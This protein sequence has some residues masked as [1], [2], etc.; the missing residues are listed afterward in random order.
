MRIHIPAK[1]NDD[2]Q[3]V[4]LVSRVASGL[5][6][7]NVPEQVFVIQID[8]WFDQKWLNFSGIGRVG[9]DSP[10]ADTAL[11]EFRQDKITFPPFSPNRVVEEY[12]FLRGENG[13]YAPSEHTSFV[14][15]R[16][17]ESSSLNL[18][19]RVSDFSDAGIFIWFSSNTQSNSRGSLMVYE[20]NRSEVNTWFAAFSKKT[21]WKLLQTCGIAREQVQLLMERSA[22]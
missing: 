3:F 17:R 7:E 2:P 19:K 12:C 4:E 18:H 5:L 14:H 9:F 1:L 8:N 20:V 21:E 13:D 15:S 16:E 10:F 11:D 6:V 22:S